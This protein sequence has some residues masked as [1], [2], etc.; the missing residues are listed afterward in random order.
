MDEAKAAARKDGKKTSRSSVR[1]AGQK[2]MDI[3]AVL[4]GM[5]PTGSRLT[6]DMPLSGKG[7]VRLVL[8]EP[9]R[10]TSV[11]GAN[12][13]EALKELLARTSG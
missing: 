11:W 4:S 8:S 9:K 2:T 5:A 13:D 7:Q 10:R 12:M 3:A 1:K 6:V